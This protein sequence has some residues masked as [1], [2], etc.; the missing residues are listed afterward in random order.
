MTQPQNICS[1]HNTTVTF[2]NTW[3]TSFVMTSEKDPIWRRQHVWKARP[4][5]YIFVKS[6][7]KWQLLLL[8]FRKT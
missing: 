8:L 1:M 3:K 6:T 4:S 7:F 5:K 2:N